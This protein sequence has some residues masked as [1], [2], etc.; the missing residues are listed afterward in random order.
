MNSGPRT[1][2][3]T[4]L[5]SHLS[6][7]KFILRWILSCLLSAPRIGCTRF[8]LDHSYVS[9]LLYG[10]LRHGFQPV[11][12]SHQPVNSAMIFEWKLFLITQKLFKHRHFLVLHIICLIPQ[13]QVLPL[14]QGLRACVPSGLYSNGSFEDFYVLDFL[15]ILSLLLS[16]TDLHY[17]IFVLSSV[18][19]NQMVM[20]SHF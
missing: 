16:F 10:A 11:G 1:C 15:T 2:N 9:C 13:F 17:V 20:S 14:N 5:L 3:S 7:P 18:I 4:H 8:P 12:L 6:S 19:Q